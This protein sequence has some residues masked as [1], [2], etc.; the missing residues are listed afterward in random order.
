MSGERE[1]EGAAEVRSED[2]VY[3]GNSGTGREGCCTESNIRISIKFHSTSG[4]DDQATHLP[5]KGGS[6]QLSPEA[7]V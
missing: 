7:G 4:P 6:M 3:R 2:C 1:R 5:K